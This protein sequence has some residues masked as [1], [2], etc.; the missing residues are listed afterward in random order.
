[1]S[2]R[3]RVIKKGV[4]LKVHIKDM[5][6]LHLI[7]KEEFKLLGKQTA[8]AMKETINRNKKSKEGNNELENAIDVEY[9]PTGSKGGIGWGVGNIGKLPKHWAAVNFGHNGYSIHAKNAQFLRFKDKNG[10]I[11]Y[12]KSV[13]NHGISP[14]NFVERTVRWLTIKMAIFKI[15]K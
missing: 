5:E 2:I 7:K 9:F 13:H 1:M 14:M 4:P 12:R 15:K 8:N 3:I 10:K 11:I 6:N